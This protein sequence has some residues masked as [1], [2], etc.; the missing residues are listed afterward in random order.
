MDL[1][2]GRW[3][4]HGPVLPSLLELNAAPGSNGWEKLGGEAS[5]LPVLQLCL[6]GVC[7]PKGQPTGLSHPGCRMSLCVCGGVVVVMFHPVMQKAPTYSPLPHLHLKSVSRE[8]SL[9]PLFHLWQHC[10]S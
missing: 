9:S 4:T 6:Y 7:F 8:P 3:E 10:L 5:P 2:R 1:E